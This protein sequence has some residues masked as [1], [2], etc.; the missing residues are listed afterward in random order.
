[1]SRSID[2]TIAFLS[3]VMIGFCVGGWRGFMTTFSAFLIVCVLKN[4]KSDEER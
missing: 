3:C 1:M 4:R 2:T